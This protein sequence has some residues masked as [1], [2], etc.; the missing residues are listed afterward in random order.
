MQDEEGVWARGVG[1]ASRRK[2]DVLPREMGQTENRLRI[3]GAVFLT[4]GDGTRKSS[5]G[6][7]KEVDMLV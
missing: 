4:I 2:I 3:M 1:V 7:G 5:K 6:G